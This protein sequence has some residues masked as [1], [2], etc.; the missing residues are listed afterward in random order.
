[1]ALSIWTQR[2]P[3]ASMP[4]KPEWVLT[5]AVWN[6]TRSLQV[7]DLSSLPPVPS[8]FVTAL[9]ISEDTLLFLNEF[10]KSITAP[11]VLTAPKST[12]WT[13]WQAQ[14]SSINRSAL[15]GSTGRCSTGYHGLGFLG[16]LGLFLMP[17]PLF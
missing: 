1:M 14:A 3:C 12:R 2:Q 11:V 6:C 8:I 16:F 9:G 10:V 17:S 15:S 4:R 13:F 7:L 5:G